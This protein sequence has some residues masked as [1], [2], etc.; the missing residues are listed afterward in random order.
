MGSSR[1]SQSPW[2]DKVGLH[3]VSN[4][5][6]HG[7]TS[8]L[9]FRLTKP[10]DGSGLVQSPVSS[11][12]EAKRIP[13][14]DHRVELS[15]HCLEVGLSFRYITKRHNVRTT[16]FGKNRD[17]NVQGIELTLDSERRVW[18]RADGPLVKAAAE[19]RRARAATDFIFD[20]LAWYA[21]AMVDS[22]VSA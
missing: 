1:G 19:E 10:S 6:G 21:M 8:V 7:N 22:S 20:K 4:E 18:L 17:F 13:V 5:S 14:L 12:N 9:D 3:A 15:G 11:I 2:E 16:T